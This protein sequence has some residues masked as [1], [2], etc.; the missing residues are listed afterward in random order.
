MDLAIN[1]RTKML[2]NLYKKLYIIFIS[3]I[4]FI[5]TVIIGILCTNS[6]DDKQHND[7]IFFQRLS[8][9]MIYELKIQK[10]IL[11]RLLILTRIIIPF[12]L[13]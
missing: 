3:S 7:S 5:I 1:W 8:T 13:Y 6:I 12:L 10:K 9:L 11:R 4:M 2:D